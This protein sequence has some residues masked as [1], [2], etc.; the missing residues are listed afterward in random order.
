M[1]TG[2][3]VKKKLGLEKF[4][5]V[6]VAR[7]IGSGALKVL[8]V[9][10][11]SHNRGYPITQSR[12][13]KA[14]RVVSIFKGGEVT[15]DSEEA[16]KYL[17]MT[18]LLDITNYGGDL[19]GSTLIIPVDLSG[20]RYID[21]AAF[22]TKIREQRLHLTKC[23]NMLN[24]Y[25]KEGEVFF[26]GITIKD[27]MK[28]QGLS[29]FTKYYAKERGKVMGNENNTSKLLDITLNK[30]EGWV[31]FDFLSEAT[32]KYGSKHKYKEVDPL[33]NFS[34]IPNP[35][36]TYTFMIRIEKFFDWLET[37]GENL[38]GK[39]TGE[40]LK[41]I[42]DISEIKIFNSSPAMHW[43]GMNYN[44]SQ[45]DAALYPTNIAPTV[46]NRYKNKHTGATHAGNQ[47]LDKESQRI[48]N[49]FFFYRN[50]MASMLTKKLKQEEII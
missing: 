7:V 39:I 41:D 28:N 1:T 29:D 42:L 44:L 21:N 16:L 50:I 48:I 26:E 3:I 33:K 14:R 2:E 36:K 5:D 27:L 19:G 4:N 23:V 13:R 12:V 24:F 34:L 11:D 9:F 25:E 6:K 35:S 32:E 31:Q 46:W 22:T 20:D 8:F 37:Y 49:Q 45:L 40:D 38:K 18:P 15:K 43:Q 30:K 10:F 47:I 17:P